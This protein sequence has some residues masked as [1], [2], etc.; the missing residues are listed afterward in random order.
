MRVVS[1]LETDFLSFVWFHVFQGQETLNFAISRG[2]NLGK[3]LHNFWLNCA[4]TLFKMQQ[5]CKFTDIFSF[6]RPIGNCMTD[7]AQLGAMS[8]GHG[9]DRTETHQISVWKMCVRQVAAATPY[10]QCGQGLSLATEPVCQVIFPSFVCF[11]AGR[12]T[13]AGIVL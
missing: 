5:C 2:N 10:T 11:C 8:V 13:D 9:G 1:V 7:P 4:S 12:P 6:V 3:G